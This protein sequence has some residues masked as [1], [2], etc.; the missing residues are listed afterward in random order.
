MNTRL[1][2]AHGY[3]SKSETANEC[4][5]LFVARCARAHSV[6]GCARLGRSGRRTPADSRLFYSLRPLDCRSARE[7]GQQTLP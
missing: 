3:N 4:Q 2:R 7:G 1:D 6:L 5:P